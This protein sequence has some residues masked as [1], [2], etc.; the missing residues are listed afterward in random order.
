MSYSNML[1]IVSDP[2]WMERPF[3]SRTKCF[4]RVFSVAQ[5]S[6]DFSSGKRK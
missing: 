3:D 6:S 5:K 1:L 2:F 4:F